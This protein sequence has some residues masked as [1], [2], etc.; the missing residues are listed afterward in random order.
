MLADELNTKESSGLLSAVDRM[1]EI[2][3]NEKITLPE[4]VVV[5]DQSVGKS[6]VLEAISG[7]QLPRAQNI[8]TRCPL[9]LRMKSTTGTEYAVIRSSKRPENEAETLHDMN[10]ISNVVMRLTKEIAGEGT[11]VSS[12]PI[13]LTVY[14]RNMPYDLTLI[15]LPG[16]TRNPLPGQPKDIHTQ[17]LN[18]INKYIEPPTAVVLHVIPASVDFATSESMKLAKEYD[19][20]CLRQL[21]AAS[22]IDKYDK[23]IAEKLLGRGPGGMQLKLGCIAVLNRNQDE[24]DENIS[25]EDMKKRE[26]EFFIKHHEA[27]QYLPDEFKGIDQLVKK[28]AIIQQDRIRSTLPQVIEELRKQIREKTLELKNIP[29]PMTSEQDCWMKFQSMINAFRESI[30]T[31]VNGDY[32]ISTRINMITFNNH[33]SSK[34]LDSIMLSSLKT[35]ENSIDSMLGDDRLAYHIYRFQRKF[36]DELTKS[37]SDF[38][39]S[40]YYKLIL[41]AID[42]GAGVSLPNFPSYQIIERLFHGELQRLPRTCFAL[43]ERIRDYLKESLWRIL[44]QTFD[45]QYIRLVEQL[46]DVIVQQIDMAADRATGRIQEILDMEYRIFTINNLYPDKVNE[47]KERLNKKEKEQQGEAAP[48]PITMSVVAPPTVQIDSTQRPDYKKLLKPI[49][50]SKSEA[51]ISKPE[52]SSSTVKPEMLTSTSLTTS[53]MIPSSHKLTFNESLAAVDIQI[54]LESYCLVVR[55]RIID[56]IS[57][58]CYHQFITKCALVID[59]VLTIACPSSDLLRFMKEPAEQTSRRENLIR[60]IKAYEDALRLGQGYL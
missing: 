59:Q 17:I 39:S 25:F 19:P 43:I 24:I 20:Q 29:I 31:K 11:N 7:I 49:S 23:G 15:D 12:T 54:T 18:L 52:D 57:Q 9:E 1:R 40:D 13:Y 21:I 35:N 27:F 3:H 26:A 44:Y 50:V 2:L 38:F 48:P 30:R 36:Q 42:D 45:T 10:E 37:F 28:L 51:L 14:K 41:Q 5:G 6:S 46:K 33:T 34:I 58:I 16:I 60:T 8:C 55:K 4:I 53:M 22:K 56:T 32:D 47:M